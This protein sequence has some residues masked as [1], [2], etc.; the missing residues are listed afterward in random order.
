MSKRGKREEGEKGMT[1]MND[2]R[3]EPRTREAV[4][5]TV[6]VYTVIV[7]YS[8]MERVKQRGTYIMRIEQKE[9]EKTTTGYGLFYPRF[10]RNVHQKEV[11]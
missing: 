11:K 9:E 5:S 4:S 3:T 10:T 2:Q 1:E 8:V 7:S 6:K